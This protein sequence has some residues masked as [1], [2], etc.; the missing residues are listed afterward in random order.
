MDCK[1]FSLSNE[2]FDVITDYPLQSSEVQDLDACAVAVENLFNIVYVNR[3][4][5]EDLED[6]FFQYRSIPK[7]YGLMQ[8]ENTAV[9]T[10]TGVATAVGPAGTTFD[11]AGLI[12]TGILR[13][14]QEPLS[15][16]G[17]GVVVCIIDTGIDY[18]LPVFQDGAG[19][20]RIRSIWDQTV[21]TGTPPE[22]FFFGSEYRRENI[23]Q[24]LQAEDPYAIVPSRDEIGHGTE[25]ASVAVGSRIDGGSGFLG[26]APNAEIVVVKLKPCKQYLRDF[27]LLPQNVPA[28]SETDLMLAVQY[29]EGF[30]DQFRRP[31]VICLG[32]G[33]SYGDHEGNSSLTRYLNTVGGRRSRAVVV[34]G[35]NEGNADHHFQAQLNAEENRREPLEV[36]VRVGENEKGF[37]MEFWGSAPNVFTVSARSPGGETTPPVRLGLRE[38]V[39]YGFVYERTRISVKGEIVEPSSGAELILLRIQDP[40]PGIWTFR[41]EAMETGTAGELHIWL[42]IR[43]FL[44]GDTYFLTPSP[45]V[46]LT[47]PIF[48]NNVIGVSAYNVANNGV[49][50]NSGRGFS[51]EGKIFPTL[52]APGVNVST[53]RG[54][55]SGTG[56]AAAMCAGA[57]AQ[58]M[59]W[60]VV[61]GNNDVVSGREV[62]NYFIRGADRSTVYSY[63]NREWG[64]GSLNMV[65][66][67]DA[68]IG[69]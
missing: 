58:F 52:A 34:C 28:Y 17:R 38:E 7:L 43:Q 35:G 45:Y 55:R 64:Y 2:Y 14:Q 49:Y 10:G 51:R 5:I 56:V 68:L 37:L 29:A 32:V 46:T 1:E 22:G 19:N 3:N 61:R 27:Y 47:E 39:T 48:G 11:A 18:T 4:S 20:S 66:T 62:R 57:V 13:V 16:T 60:A 15:L 59:E 21:Q 63:P 23:Q 42:P 69:V 33:T 53:V 9:G 24:A 31:V 65:G 41:V 26:A 6:Y 54:K 25:L 67:F 8:S 12:D 40:T 30:A 50:I 36:E 44:S